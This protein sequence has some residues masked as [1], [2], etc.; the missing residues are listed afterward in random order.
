MKQERPAESCPPHRRQN[1]D[2]KL[3]GSLQPGE[4][5]CEVPTTPKAKG[6]QCETAVGRS[7]TG[8][9]RS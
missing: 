6:V 5:A 4:V 1:V 7:E 2:A 8:G 3:T 9:G